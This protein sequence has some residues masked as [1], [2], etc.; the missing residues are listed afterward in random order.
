MLK[1]RQRYGLSPE[2]FAELETTHNGV[3]A[4][5]AEPPSAF[6]LVVDHDHQSGRVRGLLCLASNYALVRSVDG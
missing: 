4:I 6:G 2:E 1:L 3:C 5:C